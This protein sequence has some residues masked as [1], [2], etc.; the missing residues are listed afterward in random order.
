[1]ISDAR[2]VDIFSFYYIC[3]C[4]AH[5]VCLSDSDE[6]VIFVIHI[7][8]FAELHAIDPVIQCHRTVIRIVRCFVLHFI[9]CSHS[10]FQS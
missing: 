4:N 7:I 2:C 1:M 3:H 9:N 5:L 10:V 6:C 8:N